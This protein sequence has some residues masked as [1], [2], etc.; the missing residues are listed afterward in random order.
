MIVSRDDQQGHRDQEQ[1]L[2]LD[3][4]A[5]VEFGE[6]HERGDEGARNSEEGVHIPG[7]SSEADPRQA[8]DADDNV[9]GVDEC[10][11]QEGVISCCAPLLGLWI[12]FDHE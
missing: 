3:E 8:D 10:K 2:E 6:Q 4:S 7:A 9:G 1:L 5:I 12:K 11:Q